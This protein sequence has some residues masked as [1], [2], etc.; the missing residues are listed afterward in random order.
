M[1]L[2]IVTMNV[3]KVWRSGSDS[4]SYCVSIPIDMARKYKITEGDLVLFTDLD[5]AIM[6]QK[7]TITGAQ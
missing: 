6:I 3:R 7:A 4:Y 5:N 2:S 1:L